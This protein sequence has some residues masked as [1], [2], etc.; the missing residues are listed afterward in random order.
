M[1]LINC[2]ECGTEI[3]DKAAACIKC[4]YPLAS[5]PAVEKEKPK[6][7]ECGAEVSEGASECGKCGYPLTESNTQSIESENLYNQEHYNQVASDVAYGIGKKRTIKELMKKGLTESQA[8]NLVLKIKKSTEGRK[9][10]SHK[11]RNQAILGIILTLLG[12]VLFDA[13]QENGNSITAPILMA[14]FGVLFFF[15]GIFGRIKYRN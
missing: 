11:F 8:V 6:C 2:P 10:L 9:L 1:A 7:P 5:Q 14:G 12:F 13:M 15:R 4:G 3:S